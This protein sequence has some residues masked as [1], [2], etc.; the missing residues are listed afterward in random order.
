[1]YNQEPKINPDEVAAWKWMPLE[2]VKKDMEMQPEHYTAWF[3]I[4]FDKFYQH[5]NITDYESNG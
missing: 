5:I 2:E 1:K 3:K 4:I